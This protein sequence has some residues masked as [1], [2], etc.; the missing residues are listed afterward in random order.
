MNYAN[1]TANATT[2]VFTPPTGAS[3]ATVVP[4]TGIV[5]DRD[6]K[7]VSRAV[8]GASGGAI[9][10][11][12]QDTVKVKAGYAFTP[13]LLLQGMAGWW[14]HHSDARNVS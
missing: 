5:Y 8:F 6:A 7:G 9:D 13:E 11:T 3:N 12:Q 10:R 14:T 4:V 2:G 1:A